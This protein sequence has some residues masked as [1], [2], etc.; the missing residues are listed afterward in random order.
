MKLKFD[1]KFFLLLTAGSVVM[2]IISVLLH[3]LITALLVPVFGPNFD[4]PVFFLIAV[5]LCPIAFLIGAV[6]S[7][8]LLIKAGTKEELK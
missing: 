4:E 1:L 8:I 2:F 5:F 7:I 6:G 3:N